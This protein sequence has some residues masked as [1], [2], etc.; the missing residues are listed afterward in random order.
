MTTTRPLLLALLALVDMMQD[1]HAGHRVLDVQWQTLHL[2]S[3]GVVR[4]PRGEYLEALARS[5]QVPP[6]EAFRMDD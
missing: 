2:A 3:L 5:L 1:Q 4:R 6:P